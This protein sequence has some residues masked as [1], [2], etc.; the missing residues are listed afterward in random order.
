MPEKWEL[1][2]LRP[3]SNY[4]KRLPNKEALR[5]INAL[6]LIANN[7]ESSAVKPLS[8]RSEWSYRVGDRRILMRVE[9]EKREIIITRIGNRGDVY[10][11]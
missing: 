2:L 6:E 4:L 11:K 7:P 5:I 3:A 1:K 10:R 8:G 9:I